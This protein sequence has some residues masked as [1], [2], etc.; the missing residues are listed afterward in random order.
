MS[1]PQ[2]PAPSNINAPSKSTVYVSN[3]P[4]VYTN[5]DLHQIFSEYGKVIKV[6]VLKDRV[7]RLPRGVAFVLYENKEDAEACVQQCNGVE[8]G[9]RKIT[10]KIAE[11]NGRSREFIRRREYPDKS[12]C[13]E[14]GEEGHLS[15]RCPKNAL[16]TREPPPKKSRVRKPKTT[17]STDWES[18]GTLSEPETLGAIIAQSH[19]ST[20]QPS[21]EKT[22][23]KRIKMSS[24]FSD[25]ECSD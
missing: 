15:Y 20:E 6:T 9:G 24:Y 1:E 10:A 8:M 22:T 3:I 11:D 14:C 7:K 4:F 18:D 21:V 13:Y 2:R 12:K 17:K 23:R 25:E 19:F 5:N 16:G